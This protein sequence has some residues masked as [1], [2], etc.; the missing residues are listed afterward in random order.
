[1]QLLEVSGAVRPI[2]GSLGAKGLYVGVYI[3]SCLVLIQWN[4][5]TNYSKTPE[6][7][8][9]YKSVRLP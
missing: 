6:Y 5:L 7:E 9:C 3:K 4:W 8:I 1:M 2:Y